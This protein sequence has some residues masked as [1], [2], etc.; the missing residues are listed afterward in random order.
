MHHTHAMHLVYTIGTSGG[1][2][3][4]AVPGAGGAADGNR[5]MPSGCSRGGHD[6]GVLSNTPIFT[7]DSS[8]YMPILTL[9]RIYAPMYT[10]ILAMYAPYIHPICTLRHIYALTYTYSHHTHRSQCH[11]NLWRHRHNRLRR[12]SLRVRW[13]GGARTC[14]EV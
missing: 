4:D 7:L 5:R 3:R 9:R 2:T 14:A 10:P 8:I 11:R 1:R 12:R 13:V 6:S